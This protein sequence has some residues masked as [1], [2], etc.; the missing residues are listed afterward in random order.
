[1]RREFHIDRAWPR[2]RDLHDLGNPPG[3]RRHR[4]YA[5]GQENRLSDVVSDKDHGLLVGIPDAHELEPEFLARH[6]IEGREGL[7]H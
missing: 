7:V 5:I 2:Q 4:H 6:C 3:A 1:L